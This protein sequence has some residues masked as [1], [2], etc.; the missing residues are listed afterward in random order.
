M[1]NI[2]KTSSCDTD[3]DDLNHKFLQPTVPEITNITYLTSLESCDRNN[4]DIIFSDILMIFFLDEINPKIL[5]LI[6]PKIL[7][8]IYMIFI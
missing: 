5:K 3:L 4:C 1:G 6:F 8:M 2:N 7:Y